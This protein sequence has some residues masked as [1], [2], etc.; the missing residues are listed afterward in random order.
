[1]Y[2]IFLIMIIIGTA[3]FLLSPFYNSAS[4]PPLRNMLSTNGQQDLEYQKELALNE[5]KDIAFDYRMGK[6]NDEDYTKLT[7][8]YKNKAALILK[9]LDTENHQ[10]SHPKNTPQKLC[11]QCN[12]EILQEA[13]FC[14]Q[15]G[16]RLEGENNES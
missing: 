13:K 12:T 2:T 11:P 10:P 7:E 9:K 1:M 15:C 8:E 16:E 14:Q 5:I 6:L 3:Y 4:L